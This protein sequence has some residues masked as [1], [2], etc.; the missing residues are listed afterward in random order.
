L[1]Y[2]AHARG[3][4]HGS[5]VAGNV[6]IPPDT[7]A[8]C[9][10]DFGLAALFTVPGGQVAFASGDIAGFAALARTIRDLPASSAR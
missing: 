9:L 1:M 5:I 7:S 10:L 6:I 8:A 3:L 4:A 2:R